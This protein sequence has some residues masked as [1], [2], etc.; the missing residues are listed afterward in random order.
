VQLSQAEFI[1]K[2]KLQYQVKGTVDFSTAP[3]LIKQAMTFF[4]ADK[5]TEMTKVAVDLSKIVTSNSA[6]LALMLEMVKDAK[7]NN[8]DVKFTDLPD[9]LLTIAKAYGVESEIRDISQ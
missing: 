5:Q 7:I 2:D 8:I 1:Q 4:R 9:S 6:G 3:N